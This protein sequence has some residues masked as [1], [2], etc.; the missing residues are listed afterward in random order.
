MNPCGEPMECDQMNGNMVLIPQL[1][2]RT[3]GNI[4]KCFTH[5]LGDIDYGLRVRKA[6]YHLV[7]A[8]GYVGECEQNPQADSHVDPNLGLINRLRLVFSAKAFPPYPWLVFTARHA[9]VFW[10]LHWIKPY[11]D[12]VFGSVRSKL[13]L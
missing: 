10:P 1:I 11:A 13:G 2:A 7:I 4:D 6:G 9:G 8:P 3:V 12:V 5:G